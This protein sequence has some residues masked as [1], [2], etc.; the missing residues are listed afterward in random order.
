MMNVGS[1]RAY[2]N[3]DSVD[4]Q[5]RTVWDSGQLSPLEIRIAAAVKHPPQ[6]DPGRIEQ[7]IAQMSGKIVTFVCFWDRKE[8]MNPR[9]R[10]KFPV[11]YYG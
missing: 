9:K 4:H 6:V 1:K 10:I 7:I 2:F 11:G 3:L 5:D 8:K